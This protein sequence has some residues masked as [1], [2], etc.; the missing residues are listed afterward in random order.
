MQASHF[1][2]ATERIPVTVLTGFLGAGKTTLL[3]HWMQQAGMEGVAVL[4][5]EWGEVGIDHHLVEHSEDNMVLLDSGCLCCQTRGDL[6]G[7]FQTLFERSARGDIAPLTRV[8]V[9]TSG[10]ADPVPVVCTIMDERF[11]RARYHCDGVVAA[12]AAPHGLAQLQ[13][14]PETLRQVVAADRLLITQCDRASSSDIQALAMRL[15]A[16]NP[17]AGQVL[18]RHGRAPIDVVTGAGLYAAPHA[19]LAAPLP[20]WFGA[21]GLFGKVLSDEPQRVLPEEGLPLHRGHTLA[22]SRVHSPSVASFVVPLESDIPWFGLSLAMGRILQDHGHRLLRVKGLV[23]L[24]EHD[25]PLAVHC[26]Q[27]VAYPPVRL[28]RWPDDPRFAQR[29]GCLVFIA[30]GLD[31][32]QQQDIRE[33]LAQPPSDRAALR[34]AAGMAD[35]PTRCWMQQRVAMQHGRHMQHQSWVVV[36]R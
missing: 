28:H 20:R 12:I 23:G 4:V 19:N 25:R 21:G 16:L 14:H 31:A 34:T 2:D 36:P 18:V 30:Q 6:V 10:M 22:Q 7:A 33:R 5:N 15:Q 9:E 3:N 26:V 24:G 13:R 1:S 8:I 27:N 11:V 29:R 32:A 35:L 17:Q